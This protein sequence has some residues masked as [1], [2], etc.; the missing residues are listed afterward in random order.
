MPYYSNQSNWQITDYRYLHRYL[1]RM[2]FYYKDRMKEIEN[3]DLSKTSNVT[4][5]IMFCI[6]KYYNYDFLLEKPNLKALNKC[7]P[8]EKPLILDEDSLNEN[9]VYKTMNIIY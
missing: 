1:H 8:L 6:I 5:V 7:I 2:F 9:D 4:R 3:I